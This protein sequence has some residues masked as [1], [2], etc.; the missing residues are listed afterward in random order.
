MNLLNECALEQRVRRAL[1][2][3]KAER[4]VKVRHGVRA[5]SEYGQYFIVDAGTRT[6]SHGHDLERLARELGVLR[7]DEEVRL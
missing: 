1:R 5:W 6:I 3:G 2:R 4:L 7:T